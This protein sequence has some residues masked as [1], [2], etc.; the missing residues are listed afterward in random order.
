M[1]L[2][3]ERYECPEHHTDLTDLVEEALEDEGPPVAY[4][5]LRDRQADGPQ[6]FRVIVTCP[7]A[8]G[9]DLAFSGSRTR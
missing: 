7:S 8:G 9:H 6:P 4:W 1:S 3:P 2:N 5:R